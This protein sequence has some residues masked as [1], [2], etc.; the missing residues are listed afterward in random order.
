MFNRFSHNKCIL[1]RYKNSISATTFVLLSG[2]LLLPVIPIGLL[3]I[4]FSD[5][6]ALFVLPLLVLAYK[7]TKVTSGLYLLLTII[8]SMVWST[9]YGYLFLSVPFSFR[10][11]NELYRMLIPLL[12]FWVALNSEPATVKKSINLF[13]TVGTPVLIVFALLQYI[14][15]SSIPLSILNLYGRESHVTMLLTRSN[16]RIFATGSDPNVGGAIISLFLF[17]HVSCYNSNKKFGNAIAA[18]LCLLILSFTASRTVIISLFFVSFWFVLFSNN[19]KW[20]FKFVILFLLFFFAYLIW[21]NIDYVRNGLMLL[22]TG[23]N[24]SWLA[25]L[26]KFDEAKSLFLQSPIF[27]WGPAKAIHTTIVDGEYFLL[28]R[29]YGITGLI[30]VVFFLIRS[31]WYTF[32]TTITHHNKH[33]SNSVIHNT[34]TLYSIAILVVMITNN[35][36]SGYQLSIPYMIL[37]GYIERIRLDNKLSLT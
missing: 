24:N 6:I 7:K 35:F 2:A 33:W 10:D 27:G 18:L 22:S 11:I 29:R 17:Y 16:P 32:S 20:A 5:I 15:P 30:C 36:F 23:E 37:L 19:I 26:D 14:S 13:F 21:M 12:T 28:I 4:R 8:I 9:L 34:F 31:S 1:P 25:R 3:N